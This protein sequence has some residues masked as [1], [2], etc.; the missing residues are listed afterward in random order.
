MNSAIARWMMFAMLAIAAYCAWSAAA[1][2]VSL[3]PFG[4]PGW[5][6]YRVLPMLA[7]F[8]WR[9]AL[10]AYVLWLLRRAPKVLQTAAAEDDGK[11]ACARGD[12]DHAIQCFDRALKATP[13]SASILCERAW[14]YRLKGEF[15]LALADYDRAIRRKPNRAYAFAGRGVVHMEYKA[16]YDQAIKDFNQ[17]LR[18]KPRYAYAFAGRGNA[19]YL[20]GRRRAGDRRLYGGDPPGAEGSPKTTIIVH[21]P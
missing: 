4:G 1:I 8:A 9:S 17:A 13:S 18:L 12:Y 21:S 14:A 6:W 2:A 20:E 11:A 16:D 7:P 19:H 15:D 5:R 3:G 10:A